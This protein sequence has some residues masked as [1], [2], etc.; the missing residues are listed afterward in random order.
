MTKK[1]KA[2]IALKALREYFPECQNVKLAGHW[3]GSDVFEA[4][5]KGLPE[6]IG[7]PS[8]VIVGNDGIAIFPSISVM[9]DSDFPI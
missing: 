9:S 6:L 2:Q 3:R 4:A 1:E 8:V 5:T 7:I